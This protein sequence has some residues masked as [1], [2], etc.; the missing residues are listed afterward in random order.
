MGFRRRTSPD[1]VMPRVTTFLSTL[2]SANPNL[3]IGASGFCWGGY[4]VFHLAANEPHAQS[5]THPTLID[6]GYTAHPSNLALPTDAEKV[7]QP[8]SVAI[9]TLD[10]VCGPDGGEKIKKEFVKK[11]G[12]EKGYEVSFV[13]DGMHGFGVRANVEDEEQAEHTKMSDDQ[14]IAFFERWLLKGKK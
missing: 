10:V 13:K 7:I 6:A 11:G 12:E 2:R 5:E 9:G 1:V 14:A 4:Y 8:V 3:A